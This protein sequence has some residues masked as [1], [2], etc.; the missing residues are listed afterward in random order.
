M[1]LNTRLKA[2]TQAAS[3]KFILIG[4]VGTGNFVCTSTTGGT[5]DHC[6]LGWNGHVASSITNVDVRHV[7]HSDVIDIPMFCSCSSGPHV[8]DCTRNDE[9][10]KWHA[11]TPKGIPVDW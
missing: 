8:H 10:E 11:T 1:S 3:M 5:G 2:A 9:W 7:Q 6:F 4:I